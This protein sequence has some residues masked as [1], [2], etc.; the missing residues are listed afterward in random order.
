MSNDIKC[1]YCG[2]TVT[3][4]YCDDCGKIAT[5]QTSQAGVSA[6]STSADSDICPDCLTPRINGSKYCEVCRYD[7]Q[8]K[9][10]HV[11]S[12]PVTAVIE[13]IVQVDVPATVANDSPAAINSISSTP[14]IT[15]T[16]STYGK[17]SVVVIIDPSIITE[18]EYK[19]SCPQNEPERVFPLFLDENIIGRRSAK[20]GI[21]PEIDIN[22][23][24]VSHRHL[25]FSKQNDDSFTV[26]DLQ[27]ANGTEIN[28]SV[29]EPG[30][31][32]HVKDGDK[33]VIGIWTRL[34]LRAQ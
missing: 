4:G 8:A 9:S 29:L 20:K 12:T 1:Q 26:T 18:E 15:V 33:F 28:G 16:N 19:N 7:F 5:G 3:D 22:D 23:P 34:E 24:G 6:S 21:Y 27:S 10:S 32:T 14:S 13:P 25:M 2:G 17:L 11:V 31:V 30:V